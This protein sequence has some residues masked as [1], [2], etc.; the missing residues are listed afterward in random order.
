MQTEITGEMSQSSIAQ[1][2]E[3]ILALRNRQG[4]DTKRAHQSPGPQ[5][6]QPDSNLPGLGILQDKN[7][8]LAILVTYTSTENVQ[9]GFGSVC[10]A[11]MTCCT[12][13]KGRIG[14]RKT[15]SVLTNFEQVDEKR[16]GLF[17]G[18]HIVSTAKRERVAG[19][20]FGCCC[21]VDLWT[22]YFCQ[23]DGPGFHV[24]L[25]LADS[26]DV[27]IDEKPFCCYAE[28]ES[29]CDHALPRDKLGDGGFDICVVEGVDA[30]D[31]NLVWILG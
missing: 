8:L 19:R 20:W 17:I 9:A 12:A 4:R 14:G 24:P 25:A 5:P 1:G 21:C 6:L 28:H 27:V 31:H 2:V 11:I 7:I 3:H 15:A 10:C 18:G 30:L 23:F 13:R 26:A 16:L 29:V 22:P